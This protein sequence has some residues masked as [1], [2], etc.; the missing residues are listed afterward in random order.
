[1]MK[2]LDTHPVAE[3]IAYALGECLVDPENTFKT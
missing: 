3:L 1:M 2:K